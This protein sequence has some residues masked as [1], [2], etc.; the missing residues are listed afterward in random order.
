MKRPRFRCAHPAGLWSIVLLGSLVA[1]CHQSPPA[2]HHTSKDLPSG[3]LDVPRNDEIVGREVEL[4]GWAVDDSVVE[5]VRIYIDGQYKASTRLTLPR[6][7]VSKAYPPYAKPGDLHGWR[8]LVD[9]GEA[10]TRHTILIR[11]VDDQGVARDIASVVVQVI[12]R[13]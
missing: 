11:A 7:D 6:P 12:G 3:N 4:S 13:G 1:A 2:S 10:E 5:E 9:L 8:A